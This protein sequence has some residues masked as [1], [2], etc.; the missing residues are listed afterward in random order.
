MLIVDFIDFLKS[1]ALKYTGLAH[2][3]LTMG[4]TIYMYGHMVIQTC[5]CMA[6]N[7]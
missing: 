2:L 7:L 5:D 3:K 1:V 4:M 6:V